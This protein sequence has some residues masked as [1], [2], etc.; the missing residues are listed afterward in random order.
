MSELLRV[1]RLKKYFPITTGV[2]LAR[3]IGN[4][5]A[6]DDV[7]FTINRGQVLA[8]VGESGCG[9]S[10]TGRL[11]LR[12]ET[13]TA[14]RV[15]LDDQDVHALKGRDLTRYH[16]RVQAVFQN[17]WS[18]LNPRMRVRDI[19]AEPL[20]INTKLPRR[21]I[22]ERVAALLTEVGLRPAQGDL[23]PHEFSGGQ[24]Q[25]IA[26]AAALIC[27]PDLV[28]LDEPVSALDV[29]VQAQII[30]LLRSL[31]EEHGASYLLIAHNLAMVRYIADKVAVMY[32]GQIVEQAP[33]A[34]LYQ[35]P[36]HPYTQALFASSLPA[37]PDAERDPIVLSGEPPTPSNPPPGCRFH[38]RCPAVMDICRT[39][40]PVARTIGPDHTVACHL[41]SAP[42]EL[43]H[44]VESRD[45]ARV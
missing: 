34:E 29:S 38:T 14:G 20:V 39:V 18:S 28:V 37:D 13:P 27:N 8:L 32:L 23:Y 19:V 24:R 1:E 16:L 6:V 21:V 11:I 7:S 10:T 3:T 30:T 9:K 2:V 15:L 22:R 33:A 40:A 36:H 45:R 5:H 44:D 26:L 31:R 43:S 35:S 12:L 17:P 42:A 41:Y 4:V 25:R